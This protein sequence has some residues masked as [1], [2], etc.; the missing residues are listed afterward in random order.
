MRR[1]PGQVGGL[2]KT[3]LAVIG[4]AVGSKVGAQLVLGAKNVGIFGYLANAAAGGVLA[5]GAKQFLKDRA[6]SQGIVIGTVVQIITRAIGDYTPYGQY[7]TGMGMGDY[8]VSNFVT[9]QRLPDGL[10]SPQVAN[11]GG[12]WGPFAIAAPGMAGV[13]GGDNSLY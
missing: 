6:I 8:M 1:N 9:P 5:W 2:L 7:L 3:G 4:G 11:P 12:P 13:F 10:N